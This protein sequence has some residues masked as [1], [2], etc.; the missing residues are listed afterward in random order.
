M[1]PHAQA[2]T[3]DGRS[4]AHICHLGRARDI[5]SSAAAST[6]KRSSASMRPKTSLHGRGAAI[7]GLRSDFEADVR[8]ASP[9]SNRSSKPPM[10]SSAAACKSW[11]RA[12]R[13]YGKPYCHVSYTAQRL[14]SAHH[15][16]MLL[17]I[18]DCRRPQWA[19]VARGNTRPRRHGTR[20]DERRPQAPGPARAPP[21]SPPPHRAWR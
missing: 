15:P 18:A 6:S 12:V 16:P 3:S 11:Q 13:G 4:A 5:A 19:H 2:T 1:P 14:R 17:P 20:A 21:L 8:R 7:A 9:C 10:Q